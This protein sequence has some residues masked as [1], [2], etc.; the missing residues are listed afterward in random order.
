MSLRWE[1]RTDHP[2][3]VAALDDGRRLEVRVMDFGAT[4]LSDPT[5]GRVM[6]VSTTQPGLQFYSGNQ[7]DGR[8]RGKAGRAYERHAGLCLETQ[9]FPDSP[10]HPAFPNTLLRPGEPYRHSAA[11]RFFA[12]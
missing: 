7:L 8:L 11:Y 4:R 2:L 12:R 10:H 1:P 6:E 9:H 5:S 3:L